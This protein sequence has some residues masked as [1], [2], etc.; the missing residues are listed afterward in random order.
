MQVKDTLPRR[1]PTVYDQPKTVGYSQ[2]GLNFAQLQ[3]AFREVV[4]SPF[5]K[6]GYVRVM[7]LGDHKEMDFC[8]WI[9][10][11]YDNHPFVLI[12]PLSGNFSPY[13]FTKNTIVRHFYSLYFYIFT[14]F[15]LFIFAENKR[16]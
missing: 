10:I 13:N 5:V 1:L 4:G 6:T 2:I 7:L 11:A 9:Y 8:L 15:P 16:F 3:K 12:E 14:L